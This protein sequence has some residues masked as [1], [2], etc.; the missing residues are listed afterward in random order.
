MKFEVLYIYISNRIYQLRTSQNISAR[1]LS[2]S[3]G[4]CSCYIN[5][6]E[7]YKVFPSVQML[8]EICLYFEISLQEFFI[9][10]N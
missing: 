6:I 3:L 1:E 8:F 5:K 10:F 2:L 4:K 9:D 7:N